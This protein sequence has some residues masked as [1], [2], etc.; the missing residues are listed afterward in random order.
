MSQKGHTQRIAQYVAQLT[1]EKLPPPVIYK[2]KMVILDTLGVCLIGSKHPMGILT[3]KFVRDLGGREASTVIGSDFKTSSVNAALANGTMGHDVVELDD[4]HRQA[5]CHIGAVVIPAS[6]AV[7]EQERS[8]G[9][10]IITATVAG[11]DVV[12]RIAFAL[13]SAKMFTRNLFSSSICGCF[14]AAASAGKL[15]G[16]DDKQ[17]ANAFGLAASQA[18]GLFACEN[19]LEH[20]TRSLQAG[21]P[22]RDGIT[23]AMLAQIGY[24]GP[25]SIFEGNRNVLETFS[26]QCILEP[27]T[28]GLGED[29]EIMRTGFKIYG[30]CRCTHPLIEGLVKIMNQHNIQ[31]DDIGELTGTIN[32]DLRQVID[33]NV[34]MTHNGQYVLAVAAFDKNVTN[35]LLNE[36][37]ND[38]RVHALAKRIKIEGD[39]SLPFY[40]NS[41]VTLRTKSGK[42]FKE[43]I[44]LPK[45]EPENPL[46]QEEVEKKFLELALEAISEDQAKRIIKIAN[47]LETLKSVTELGDLLRI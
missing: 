7:A 36:R 9:K 5:C 22:A 31:P 34:L 44:N 3:T 8:S 15:L 43:I 14:G 12:S 24:V 40:V 47:N 25:P 35:K 4:V 21:I 27:L 41:A 33:N 39:A 11:Y 10:D 42:V 37:R 26:G 6:L 16:L 28:K 1:Y 13:G 46:T 45:G 20:Y 30:S 29:F 32:I 17:V 23:A 2:T 18:S 19:E 38:S